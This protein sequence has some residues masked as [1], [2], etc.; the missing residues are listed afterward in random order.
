[1]A[2]I[3]LADYLLKEKGLSYVLLGLAQ[4]D[5]VE[6]RFGQYRQL[7]GANYFVSVR[8]V[9]DVEKCIR[10]KALARFPETFF[11]SLKCICE[12]S[13]ECLESNS[14]ASTIEIVSELN[15]EHIPVKCNELGDENIL[16]YVAG[17]IA[18]S[19]IKT[20]PCESC[21]SLIAI[22]TNT[23]LVKFDPT[24]A[25]SNEI[26]STKRQFL[27]QVNRGGLCTPT[28]L[29]FLTCI[30]AWNFYHHLKANPSLKSKLFTSDNSLK[31]FCSAFCLQI[32]NDP[33][34]SILYEQKCKEEHHYSGFIFKITSKIFKV[35][36]KNFVKEINEAVYK[37]TKRSK[38][39]EST[40][41]L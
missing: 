28:D 6:G 33:H 20:L 38:P 39:V 41:S 7:S 24:D 36:T 35:M 11:E 2:L 19:V 1:M 31:T 9:L 34:A 17:Y 40:N 29:C 8:Q 32:Q 12:N 37:S 15:L 21:K 4:S 27:D 14:E 23:P 3:G 22:D 26:E 25:T 10:L 5:P 16:F 30:Y 18:R 13:N